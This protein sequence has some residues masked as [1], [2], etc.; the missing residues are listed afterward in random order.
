[1]KKLLWDLAND[2]VDIGLVLAMAFSV[3]VIELFMLAL[4][5]GFGV[6]DN[7]YLIVGL[8]LV[9]TGAAVVTALD[10][11]DRVFPRTKEDA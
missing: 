7:I 9:N 8:T 1:M 4:P 6:Y 3:V 10:A 2:L 5:F 11:W